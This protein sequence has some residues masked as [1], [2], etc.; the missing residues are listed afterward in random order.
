MPGKLLAAHHTVADWDFQQGSQYRSLDAT[1]FISEPTSLKLGPP[2]VNWPDTVLCRIPA[3]QLLPQGEVRTWMRVH[4]VACYP[5]VFR[6]QHALGGADDQ[7]CYFLQQAA[8]AVYLY[9][10]VG[11]FSTLCDQ[12]TGYFAIDTWLHYRTVWYNG[13]TPGEVPALCVDYYREIAGEW[14][15][16]GNTMYDTVNMFKDSAINRVGF[17]AFLYPNTYSWFDDT[18]IWGPV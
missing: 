1:Y 12:T 16:L 15:K 11:G 9:R 5:A 14:I 7:N 4:M 13:K 2:P 17:H 10:M 8:A 18:E 6:N 3:T